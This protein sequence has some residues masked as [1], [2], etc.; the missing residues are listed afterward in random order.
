MVK[1]EDAYGPM[2]DQMKLWRSAAHTIRDAGRNPPV[3]LPV[4]QRF[5]VTPAAPEPFWHAALR[6]FGLGVCQTAHFPQ[7]FSRLVVWAGHLRGTYPIKLCILSK[8]P[9]CRNQY[10]SKP[11]SFENLVAVLHENYKGCIFDSHLIII[12]FFG[13]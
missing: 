10:L 2:L 3:G 8:Y 1:K 13:K 6:P 7:N 9:R 5:R 12:F 11:V 4:L